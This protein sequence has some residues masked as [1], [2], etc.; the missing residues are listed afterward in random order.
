M[1]R[2]DKVAINAFADYMPKEDEPPAFKYH[3]DWLH[4]E[5][6]WMAIDF[7]EEKKLK[8]SLAYRISHEAAESVR[9]LKAD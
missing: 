1:A 8:K 4:Q 6:N 7:Q 9:K 5:M 3:R 2:K